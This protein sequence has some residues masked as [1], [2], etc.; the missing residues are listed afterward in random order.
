MERDLISA[1]T[2]PASTGFN[3]RAPYG[4]RLLAMLAVS[5]TFGVSIHAPRME[6]DFLSAADSQLI[7]PVSIHAPR[8]ERDALARDVLVDGIMFQSTRPVWS[9]T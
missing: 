8:M 7:A 9:A 4:A 5:M 2:V 6:R 3:P 1:I